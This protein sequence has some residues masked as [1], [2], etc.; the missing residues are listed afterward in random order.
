VIAASSGAKS[1]SLTDGVAN[2][3]IIP[4]LVTKDFKRLKLGSSIKVAKVGVVPVTLVD[5]V[6]D[7]VQFYY[8]P[9]RIQQTPQSAGRLFLFDQIFSFCKF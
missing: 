5:W 3:C 4:A 7:P 9:L 1:V 2:V 8:M 6:L